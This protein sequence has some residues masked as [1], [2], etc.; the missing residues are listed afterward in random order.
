MVSLG[1]F[2]H[3]TQCATPEGHFVVLAID[4]RANLREALSAARGMPV[5]DV[6]VGEFKRDVVQALSSL[7]SGVLGDPAFVLGYGIASGLLPGTQGLIAPVEVTNYAV[8]PSERDVQFIAGWN[9]EKAKRVGLSGLK[10]L[11]YFHPESPAAVQRIRLARMMADVCARFDIPLF[12][13]PV[14]H[15]LT[16][17]MKME[18]R[19]RIRSAVEMARLMADTGADVLKLEFPVDSV[20]DQ[21]PYLWEDAAGMLNRACGSVPWVL[22]SGGV[23]GSVFARQTEIACAAGCS[24]VMVGRALW[25]AA[26]KAGAGGADSRLNILQNRARRDLGQLADI[27]RAHAAPFW[28]K[29]GRPAPEFN[30]YES[31]SG[32]NGAK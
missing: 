14:L 7:C 3:L 9:V 16:P 15:S 27:V 24:G 10:L 21:D 11:M 4:H 19:A 26:V 6:E 32:F 1:K 2:R 22:L 12:L 8:H 28:E 20:V 30:W 25:N 17:S 29:T 23:D 31:Y 18:T 13:E 5:D